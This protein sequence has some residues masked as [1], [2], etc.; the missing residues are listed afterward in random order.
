MG[1]QL[2]AKTLDAGLERVVD[3]APIMVM[4]PRDHWP[5]PPSSGWSNWAMPPPLA[6]SARR[7]ACTASSPTP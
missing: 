6:S 5:M 4:P 1:R 2:V 3:M 7:R